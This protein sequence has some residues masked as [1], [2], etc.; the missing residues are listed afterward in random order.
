LLLTRRPVT[1][2]DTESFQD[3]DDVGDDFGVPKQ[4]I[5][6]GK[7][8][9]YRPQEL[10][11][12]SICAFDLCNGDRSASSGGA[13]AGERVKTASRAHQADLTPAAVT[14]VT[15]TGSRGDPLIHQYPEIDRRFRRSRPR[16]CAVSSACPPN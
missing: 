7:A 16:Q 15:A 10:R 5:Y 14:A 1:T 6:L 3:V 4:T 11:V 13:G 8:T 12:D 2:V 9:G